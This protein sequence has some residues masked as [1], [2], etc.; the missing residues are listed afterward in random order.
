M[1]SGL[2][3]LYLFFIP[4]FL[5]AQTRWNLEISFRQPSDILSSDNLQQFYTVN[6]SVF[7][8]YNSLGQ[9]QYTYSNN[10]LG[11]I[12]SVD[13]HYALRPIVFY[14]NQRKLVV[15]DNTLSNRRGVVDLTAKGFQNVTLVA[16]AA[17]NNYWFYDAVS[18]ALIRVSD[19]F[20]T[21]QNSGNL[22]QLLQTDL[23][24]NFLIEKDNWVY[25]NNPLTGILVFDQ[26]GTYYKTIPIVGLKQFQVSGDILYYF[27]HDHYYAYNMKSFDTAE[28]LL[29]QKH[30]QLARI[31]GDQL[32][33]TQHDS[34][35]V[36]RKE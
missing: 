1:K 4:F 5:L 7:R 29:P 2:L 11:D 36:Y 12:S 34:I 14:A 13:V 24:P 16:G 8:K 27:L 10:Q 31:E 17:N 30:A 33:L 26:Y 6:G 3:S 15:L 22:G 23:Q 9:L 20:Q 28:E 35:F 21:L 25:L 18:F 32:Y 19:N